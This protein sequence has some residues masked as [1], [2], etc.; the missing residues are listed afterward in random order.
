MEEL[1]KTFRPEFLNRLDEVILFEQLTQEENQIIAR[2]MLSDLS[3]RLEGLGVALDAPEEAVAHLS[4]AGY[5][6]TNGARPL[7]R[8]IRRQ[9]EDP[10]AELLLTGALRAG[11]TLHLCVE[12]GNVQLRAEKI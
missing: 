12:A 2:R 8:T 6:D 1:K 7:R 10:A 3:K 5:D 9:V 11:G 4:R